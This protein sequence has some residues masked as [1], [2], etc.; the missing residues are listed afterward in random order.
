MGSRGA[1]I[2]F[3]SMP[4]EDERSLLGYILYSIPAPFQ[5]VSLFDGRDDWRSE[6]I[7]DF[8][9]S[10]RNNALLTHLSPYTQY[11]F[12]VKTYTIASEPRCGQSNI[13]YFRTKA[14]Q[15]DRVSSLDIKPIGVDKIVSSLPMRDASIHQSI[16]EPSMFS[17][18]S[19]N[20]LN[21]LF[22]Y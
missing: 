13:Y 8:K 10:G 6:D 21:F 4:Y 22:F 19:E 14:G 1:V 5:N 2:E 7:T 20:P 11:A 16:N 9:L 15:P 18:N 17:T 12:Y 3:D